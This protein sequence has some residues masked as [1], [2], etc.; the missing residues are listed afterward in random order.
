MENYS[1]ETT[2]KTS[3]KMTNSFMLRIK[4]MK[5]LFTLFFF[6]LVCLTYGIEHSLRIKSLG[7]DFAYLIPDYETDLYQNPQLLGEKLSGI[8]FEPGLNEPLTMRFLSR[9]FGL[10]SKYWG[11]YYSEKH[12]YYGLTNCKYIN[13]NDLWMLDLRGK[14]WKFLADEVWNWYNDLFYNVYDRYYNSNDYHY[15]RMVKY[16]FSAN[17]ANRLHRLISLQYRTCGGILNHYEINKY[18]SDK[19]ICEHWLLL[20]SGKLGVFYHN[21]EASNHFTSWYAEIGGPVANS[22]IDALPYSVFSDLSQD[23][24]FRYTYFAKTFVG[25]IGWAKAI[26]INNNSFVAIGLCEHFLLQR[27]D[28]ADTN[29]ELRGLRNVLSIPIAMEYKVGKITL[30]TGTKVFYTIN[31]NREWNSDSTL[32]YINEHKLNFGYSF[33]LSWQPDKHWAIDLYNNSDLSSINSWAIYLKHF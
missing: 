28:R 8:S 10:C 7:T 32:I 20:I 2:D 24:D 4:K 17:G 27:T 30:R 3:G 11:S 22:E 33:G 19:S 29:I 13:I 14:I 21:A 12:S 9:R 26:P 16:L 6:V 25:K 31:S 5:K 15:N 1:W 23:F 18:Y